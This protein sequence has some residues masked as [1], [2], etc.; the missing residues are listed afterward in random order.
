MA[1]LR[2]AFRN[3]TDRP[4]IIFLE[5]STSRYRLAPEEQLVLF[6]DDHD[7]GD[8]PD[9]PLVIEYAMDGENPQ[10]TIWTQE[11]TMFRSDGAEAD[12]DF[13]I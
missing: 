7:C 13:S 12:M 11:N 8:G 3:S 10:I 4:L 2:Q 9:T 5:L 1:R 6:Y